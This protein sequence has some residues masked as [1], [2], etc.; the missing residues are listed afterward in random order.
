MRYVNSYFH[1]I[2]KETQG[3]KRC[4][5]LCIPNVVEVPLSGCEPKFSTFSELSF[6]MRNFLILLKCHIH[7]RRSLSSNLVATGDES[8]PSSSD[9]KHL[10]CSSVF[11]SIL[12]FQLQYISCHW[13]F[14]RMLAKDELMTILQKCFKIFKSTS[15]KQLGSTAKRI[16]EFLAQFQNL[17]GEN[18][19]SC[20][21]YWLWQSFK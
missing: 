5:L 20:Q 1:L 16:E 8:V 19:V 17:D 18:I 10:I 13:F 21:F 2:D 3:S 14:S 15:E 4:R 6:I 7:W 11:L 9:Q 12:I